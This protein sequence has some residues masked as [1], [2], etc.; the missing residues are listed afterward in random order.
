MVHPLSP[1]LMAAAL[2]TPHQGQGHPLGTWWELLWCGRERR[3][4]MP[5]LL[6]K[7]TIPSLQFVVL[8]AKQQ[9]ALLA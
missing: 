5:H 1:G 9:N 2:L 7:G 3:K 8:A 6:R 4:K